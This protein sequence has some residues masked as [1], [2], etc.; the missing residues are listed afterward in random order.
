MYPKEAITRAFRSVY[1]DEQG[2]LYCFFSPGRVNLIGEHIDYNGGLVLPGTLSLG[3][4]GCMR[5]RNDHKI[6]LRSSNEPGEALI[7]LH[8]EIRHH[9]DLKWINY[10]LGVIKYLLDTGATLEGCDILLA[11]DLPDGAGLSSSAAIEVLL[12]YMLLY[13]LRGDDVDR[14]AIAQLCQKVENEFVGVN[15]GIM[16]QFAVAL[17]KADCAM[18]LDTDTLSYEY[19]PF[20]LEGH[21][22]LIL[23]TRKKRELSESNYNE[24]RQE[25]ETALTIIQHHKP[26]KTLVEAELTDI[27]CIPDPVLRKRARHVIT[28]QQRVLRSVVALRGSDLSEFGMLLNASHHSLK[29]DYEVTG[30]EL[31]TIVEEALQVAGCL[32]ARMTGAGFGGCAIALVENDALDA[33]TRHVECAYGRKTN[34]QPAIYISVMSDGVRLLV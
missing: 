26:I 21:K 11:S 3:I 27:E 30:F 7:D 10:P 32:G 22:L 2:D 12:A 28:E 4:S 15:C 20:R 24:R 25:C 23:N 14:V 33:F 34:R 13:P 8:A 6:R 16:D 19:V 17:G 1:G 29:E 5:S 9:P 31:D 18:L